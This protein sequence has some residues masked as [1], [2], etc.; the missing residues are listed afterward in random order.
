MIKDNRI[1][2]VLKVL[3]TGDN[4][5]FEIDQMVSILNSGGKKTDR[6]VV[7]YVFNILQEHNLLRSIPGTAW[8]IEGNEGIQRIRQAYAGNVFKEPSDFWK[9]PLNIS[10]IIGSASTIAALVLAWMSYNQ[11][12]TLN[13]L[14]EE[15]KVLLQAQ[16][17]LENLLRSKETETI[18]LQQSLS[19][20]TTW[21]IRL[22]SIVNAP[23]INSCIC[24]YSETG[25]YGT[26]L[27]AGSDNEK[28]FCYI[29]I[30]NQ[31]NRLLLVKEITGD[32]PKN[33]TNEYENE[34]FR[35]ILEVKYDK[36]Y[37]EESYLTK[38]TL[39][40]KSK[41]ANQELKIDAS[42]TCYC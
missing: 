27:M 37:G 31:L 36:P 39:R 12:Q 41:F 17:S 38:A 9:T 5:Q 1:H 15:K 25:Q 14:E 24:S 18:G 23:E 4:Y 19:S 10:S 32:D 34:N 11:V 7:G 13:K 21:Q 6:H 26:I 28:Q 30:D 40:V 42:G 2:D 16:D 35:V 33:Y 22:Q 3:S 8:I 20:A 29:Q